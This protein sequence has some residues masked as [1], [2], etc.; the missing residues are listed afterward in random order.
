ML[1]VA[2]KLASVYQGIAV[3]TDVSDLI[4]LPQTNDMLGESAF[5]VIDR[6]ARYSAVLAYDLPDGGCS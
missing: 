6:M 2:Q 5:E 3:S 1:G 4:V